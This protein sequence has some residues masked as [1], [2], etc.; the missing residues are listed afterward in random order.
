VSGRCCPGCKRKSWLS[1]ACCSGTYTSYSQIRELQ[2]ATSQPLGFAVQYSVTTIAALGL[3]FYYSWKLTLVTLAAVPV[4]GFILSFLAKQMQ[5]SIEA[6][7]AE[8]SKAAK[9]TNSAISSIE[10]V[11]CYNGQH[12]ETSQYS[13][14]IQ[15]AA[16]FYLKQ[17]R[18]SSLQIGFVRVVTLSMFVQ[19]FW[20]GSS[21]V[22]SG[23]V[24][25][26]DVLTTFWGCLMATRSV[27]QI[28]PQMIILEKGRAAGASLMAILQ[29][30]NKGKNVA[31]MIG[32]KTPQ[33]C[34]GDIEV[35][36]VREDN[37]P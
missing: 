28:L 25:A 32:R 13:Q 3:A 2:T 16:K 36:D 23:K 4:S 15:K 21:L 17:A 27:E 24:S 11:K 30:V 19:G 29:Q 8:L 1:P 6:Q 12:F 37:L 14:A 20:Y 18:S 5:P 26:G 22:G 33:F 35:R 10:T 31:K 9:L 34:D 7:Q